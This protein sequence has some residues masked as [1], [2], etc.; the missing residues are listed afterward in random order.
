[1]EKAELVADRVR[2][3]VWGSREEPPAERALSLAAIAGAVAGALTGGAFAATAGAA[4]PVIYG[5]VGALV[6][7]TLLA[8]ASALV[9]RLWARR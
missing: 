1:M 2:A 7:S 5:G 4:F 3:D 6:G 9:A 8:G